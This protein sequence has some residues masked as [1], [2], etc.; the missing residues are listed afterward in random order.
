MAKHFM[1]LA[2]SAL[3]LAL[4]ACTVGPE[5]LRPQPELPERFDQAGVA[6]STEAA[7]PALWRAFRDPALDAFIV[8]ALEAN[9]RL[10]QAL[11]RLDETRA[12]AGLSTY[13]LIPTVGIGLDGERSS[14]SGR[15]PFLPPEQGRTDT[16][17]AGFDAVWEID[18]FGSLRNPKRAI[19]RRVEADAAALEHVHISL[20]AEVAQ[21]LFELRGAHAQLRLAER[22]LAALS[23]SLDLAEALERAGRRSALDTA[24]IRAQRSALAADFAQTEATLARAEQRLAV[25]TAQ[26]VQIVREQV[27]P[28]AGLP[29]LPPLVAVGSPEDWLR[30][31]PDLREA[32][33]RLAA[34]YADIGTATSNFYPRL[35]LLGGFGWTAQGFGEIGE[36][37]SER[38]RW[39]PSLRWNILDFGRTRQRVRAAEARADG[40]RAVFEDTLLRALEETENAFASLRAANRSAYDLGEAAAAAGEAS[41][42]ARLRYEAGADD[43]LSLLDS[44]RNRIGFEQRAV[45]ARVAQATALAALYKALAGDFAKPAVAE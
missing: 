42:L 39:G 28:Q 31:R 20:V 15:D 45:Q 9:P 22:N 19:D 23:E 3:A 27:D 44:E 32:E 30:R 38:W 29:E 17:R 33:R 10:S 43:A 13:S 16:W 6:A 5:Y 7:P 36:A 25:L 12:L 24:R 26:P 2:V 40:A 34:A 1:P 11:A 4:S 8:R 14:P 18:L 21:A 41:R 35:E 37:G